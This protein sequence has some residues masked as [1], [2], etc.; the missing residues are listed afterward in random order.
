MIMIKKNKKKLLVIFIII[1]LFIFFI[2]YQMLYLFQLFLI[3]P[4]EKIDLQYNK[5]Y[6]LSCSKLNILDAND[7]LKNGV[8]INDLGYDYLY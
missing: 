7:I 4:L 5:G 8:N 6:D 3:E 2:P 1:L